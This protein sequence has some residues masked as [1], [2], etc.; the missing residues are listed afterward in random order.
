MYRSAMELCAQK[1]LILDLSVN[2]FKYQF[3]GS[4]LGAVWAI[5]RPLIF[6]LVIWFI[7]SSG[8]KNSQAANGVP[9]ILYLLTGY[10]PWIFF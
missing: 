5:I 9:F 8:F 10:L 1:R 2:E 7:F 4:Y 6:V 3:L